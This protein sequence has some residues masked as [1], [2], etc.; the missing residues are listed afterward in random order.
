MYDV[1]DWEEFHRARRVLAGVGNEVEIAA[2]TES[3]A[4]HPIVDEIFE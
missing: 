1:W 3:S 4:I 2:L